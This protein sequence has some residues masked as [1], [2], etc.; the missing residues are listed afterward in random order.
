MAKLIE[1]LDE[2]FGK[3]APQLPAKVKE[4]I[5]KISP[6]L[7]IIGVIFII[8]SIIPLITLV[9]GLSVVSVYAAAVMPM[10]NV[11][12]SFAVMI[13]I[14]IMYVIAIPGLFKR[15]KK[16]WNMMFY[17]QLVSALGSLVSYNFIS[18]IIG[19]IISF[20]ILFQVRS[21]YIN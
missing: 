1:T 11:Y 13:I 14:A 6:Y 3:K 9:F 17:A 7:A 19:L 16:S 15:T 4:V 18:L 5:V 10:T 2:Y 20:Y 12:I 8:L 21:Y